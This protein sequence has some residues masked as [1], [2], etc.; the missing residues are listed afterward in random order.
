M[1][2]SGRRLWPLAVLLHLGDSLLT[3]IGIEILKITA[4]SSPLASWVHQHA[5]LFDVGASYPIL[6]GLLIHKA[7]ILLPILLLWRFY[8]SVG[9]I[10]PDPWRSVIPTVVALRGLYLVAVNAEI[11]VSVL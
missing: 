4:E 2:V 9:N 3:F 7:V 1:N 6:A 11:L 5:I 8:P 10:G